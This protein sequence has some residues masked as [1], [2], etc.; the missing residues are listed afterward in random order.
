LARR[1]DSNLAHLDHHDHPDP[2]VFCIDEAV[3]AA[4]VHLSPDS[5]PSPTT[6]KPLLEHHELPAFLQAMLEEITKLME[7]FDAFDDVTDDDVRQA[8]RDHPGRV[9]II[10]TKWVLVSKI[11]EDIFGSIIA[12][13]KEARLVACE[14]TD[15]FTVLNTWS[16]TIMIDSD[17]RV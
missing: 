7:V 3:A 10:P 9:R 16:P 6:F 5:R 12:E 11:R 13:R 8:L 14:A 15:R 17:H 1:V 2:L 4:Y